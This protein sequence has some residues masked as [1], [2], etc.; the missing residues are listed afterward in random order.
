MGVLSTLHGRP[1]RLGCAKL[2]KRVF[3]LDLT[4]CPHCGG[5]LSI[6]AAILQRQAIEKIPNHLGFADAMTQIILALFTLTAAIF[7][8]NYSALP[9]D[10]QLVPQLMFFKNNGVIG[11]LLLLAAFCFR[12]GLMESRQTIRSASTYCTLNGQSQRKTVKIEY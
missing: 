12:R 11:G 8:H 1:M 6:I 3:N 9:A 4:H 2:L 5:D 10:Q 7:F